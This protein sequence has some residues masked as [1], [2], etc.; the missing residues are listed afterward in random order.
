MD[1]SETLVEAYLKS[2]GFADVCFEPD[3]KVPPDFLVSGCIA[4]EARRLNQNYDDGS[5]N[6][7]RGLEEVSRP[8]RDWIRKYLTGL[9]SAPNAGQSWYVLFNFSRPVP[10]W[11]DLK[12]ELDA[13]LLPFKR[14]PNPQPLTKM[15][16]VG[17]EFQ[18]E[19]LRALT[20]QETFF[21][22]GI[23]S[24]EQSGGWLI[25]DIAQNLNYC[26]EEKANKILKFRDKYPEWWLVF[27]DHIGYGL[28]DS[29]KEQLLD[30]IKVDPKYFS[31]IILLDPHDVKRVFQ[32][33]P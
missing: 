2:L 12:R 19:L 28:G 22:L 18:I 14:D 3:G 20:P 29:E 26:I 25:G 27:P 24:D 5:G 17:S 1:D 15:L 9:G 4:V 11:K 21:N 6:G 13:L 31:K 23:Q 33:Y 8:L 16:N 32:V 7:L 10:A 30:Q